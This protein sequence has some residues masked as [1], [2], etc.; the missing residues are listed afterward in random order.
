[1]YHITA[2][3]NRKEDIFLCNDDR[4]MYLNLIKY[5]QVKVGYKLHAYCLMS[6][7]I[8]LLIETID[9][10]PGKILQLLHLNYSKHFNKKYKHVGHVFQN[11]YY[12]KIIMDHFYFTSACSY[13]H[14]NS[15]R[16]SLVEYEND[17]L[18]SSHNYYLKGESNSLMTKELLL[19]YLPYKNYRDWFTSQKVISL[20]EN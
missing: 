8:H 5:T 16:E 20:K 2:I 17:T 12:D 10:P 14:L 19:S 11:R 3:G 1:M 4:R 13:I 6:N 15:S 7:H 9:S 18:W